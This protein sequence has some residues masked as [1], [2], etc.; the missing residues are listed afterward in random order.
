MHCQE[1]FDMR[2]EVFSA[3]RAFKKVLFL[4][5]SLS[6]LCLLCLEFNIAEHP[7]SKLKLI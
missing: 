6:Y 7:K 2:L 1:C 3:L 4:A 5:S